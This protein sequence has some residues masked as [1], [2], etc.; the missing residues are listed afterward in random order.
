MENRRDWL[1]NV[2]V[3]V[4]Y[5]SCGC[6]NIDGCLWRERWK[7]EEIRVDGEKVRSYVG[8]DMKGNGDLKWESRG[9]FKVG[10]E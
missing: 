6:D 2:K 8:G 4:W 10:G 1:D 9:M 5:G 7:R 3:G